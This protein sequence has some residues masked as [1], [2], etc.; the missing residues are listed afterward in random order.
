MFKLDQRLK[1]DA[2]ILGD[3]ALSKLILVDN[4][5][6]PWVI[7]VPKR[8]NVSE[9]IDLNNEDRILLLDEISLVSKKMQQIF[10]P[11]KLNIAAL[12]NIVPQLH[13]HVIAR[14]TQDKAWPQPVFGKEKEAYTTESR[15]RII[16]LFK[17]L[18]VNLE[19]DKN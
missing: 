11:D 5:L 19:L 14:Y 17:D 2:F 4:S 1:N 8:N 16:S 13:V 18:I 6:F 3:M 10:K 7:L 12:G 15:E 9:I